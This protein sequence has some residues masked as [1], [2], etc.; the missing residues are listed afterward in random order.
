MNVRMP[1]AQPS[2]PLAAGNRALPLCFCA[3]SACALRVYRGRT[4]LEGWPTMAPRLHAL[5]VL[6]DEKNSLHAYV[7]DF[8]PSNPREVRTALQLV[9]GRSA[10]ASTRLRRVKFASLQNSNRFDLQAVGE[11][12]RT[13]EEVVQFQE[14]SA[15]SRINL[16]ERNC[17]HFEDKF[18]EYLQCE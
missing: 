5:V 6:V 18:L 1:R 4:P 15:W 9:S 14:R 7:V 13:L 17:Y 3:P 2:S 11:T 10:R 8:L 12:K 16:L